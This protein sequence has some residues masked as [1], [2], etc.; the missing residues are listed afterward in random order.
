MQKHA[1]EEEI[2]AEMKAAEA[3]K[4]AG[5][6]NKK[7]SHLS[8]L[9]G[10]IKRKSSDDGKNVEEPSDSKRTKMGEYK[11]GFRVTGSCY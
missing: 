4:N 9:A 7:A 6:S 11:A 2:R 8:L 1:A 10:A 5:G 3:R